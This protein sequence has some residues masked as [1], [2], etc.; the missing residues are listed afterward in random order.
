[1]RDMR[2]VS[3]NNENS[4][5]LKIQFFN[6]Q[7]IPMY[8]QLHIFL[9]MQILLD[10]HFIETDLTDQNGL[11]SVCSTPNMMLYFPIKKKTKYKTHSVNYLSQP[12]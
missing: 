6:C 4:T 5:P 12:V 11:L 9:K 10:F 2:L 7:G 1:M 3:L 8:P